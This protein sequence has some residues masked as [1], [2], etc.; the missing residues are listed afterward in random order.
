MR[1]EKGKIN[2]A[3]ATRDLTVFLST[4]RGTPGVDLPL[5]SPAVENSKCALKPR[6]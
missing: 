3:Q 2:V 1:E 5:S 6:I 4:T